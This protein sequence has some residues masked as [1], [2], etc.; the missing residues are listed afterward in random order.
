M[1]KTRANSYT[2]TQQANRRWLARI[3][4][5]VFSRIRTIGLVLK[6]GGIYGFSY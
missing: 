4:V 5:E 6:P 2:G 1:A 3:D